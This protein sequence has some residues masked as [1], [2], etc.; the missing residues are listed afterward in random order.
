MLYKPLLLTRI[1]ID[2]LPDLKSKK[3]SV[4][5]NSSYRK[6]HFAII[7]QEKGVDGKIV[8]VM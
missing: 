1:G 5:K 8:V 2:A 3:A 4:S 7:A 6:A